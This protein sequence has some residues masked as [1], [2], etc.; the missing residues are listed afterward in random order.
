[1]KTLIAVALATVL[2]LL[3]GW[4][5]FAQPE[6]SAAAKQV[7]TTAK[8]PLYWVAPMDSSYRRDGPGKSPMGMDLVPVYADSE[9][10][11][12]GE[13]T[14]APNVVQQLGVSTYVV[15]RRALTPALDTVGFVSFDEQAL[16]H[17]HLRATGWVSGLT[18]NS[19]GDPVRKGQKLF[20]FYSPDIRNTQQEFLQALAGDNP[21]LVKASREKLRAQGVPEAEIA[22]IEKSRQIK[23]EISYYAQKSGVVASLSVANGSYVTLQENALSI[24]PLEQVW[25]I[26]EVFERQA[27]LLAEGQAVT[28]STRAHPGA[29]WQ[30]QVDYVYPVLNPANRTTRA[31]IVVG[32]KDERLKPN[33]LMDV[34][35]QA[36]PFVAE[37]LVPD[38]AVIRTGA[39]VRVVRELRHGV[40]RSQAVTTGASAQGFT[41]ILEGLSEGD[42]VVTRAQFLIDS[43]SNVA[44]ELDR[45]DAGEAQPSSQHQNHSEMDHHDMGHHHIN[46]SG[47]NHSEMNHSG[48]QK[49]SA[50]NHAVH[51]SGA[52]QPGGHDH[53]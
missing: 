37:N 43:E 41:Q 16:V 53:D 40:F 26:A 4:L 33:M 10:T 42:R 28:L 5:L 49:S 25:V 17:L 47:M 32:N 23:S 51:S 19:L 34:R 48:E 50:H 45:L 52:N 44:A 30:G 2:G 13:V 29:T 18:V 12:A 36:Q 9:Q 7:E 11:Q 3:S 38:S 14:V 20:D 46:H 24:G 39:G 31:R 22:A 21:R 1:M 6:H 35:I 15:E 27:G 8:Q